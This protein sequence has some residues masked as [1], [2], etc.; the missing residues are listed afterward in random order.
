MFIGNI[1]LLKKKILQ[2]IC[3]WK[4]QEAFPPRSSLSWPTVQPELL[5]HSW[6]DRHREFPSQ[7]PS[8]VFALRTDELRI[9]SSH[10]LEPIFLLSL[11]KHYSGFRGKSNFSWWLFFHYDSRLKFHLIWKIFTYNI[12][13]G[14]SVVWLLT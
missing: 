6:H 7:S 1:L 2:R 10:T 8:P 3:H 12:L 13:S 14:C 9:Y 5:S 11:S 4:M